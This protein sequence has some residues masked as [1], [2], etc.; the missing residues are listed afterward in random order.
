MPTIL[1][2]LKRHYFLLLLGLILAAL[3][4][5]L[6]GIQWDGGAHM[7]P[8]ER[9]LIMV[10]QRIDIPTN[11]NP[12][13][14]NYGSFPLYLLRLT[15]QLL[16]ATTDT[17]LTTYDG[18][19][20]VGRVLS[21]LADIA[22]L[23]GVMA[24]SL[25]IFKSRA[26]S[27]L[28]GCLWAIA[29][30][31]IQN[32][33]FFVVDVFLTALTTWWVYT[34]LL[35]VHKP[36]LK[37]LWANGILLGLMIATKFTAII[38]IPILFA[39][40][41]I[42][43]RRWPLKHTFLYYFIPMSSA[44]IASFIAMPFMYLEAGKF[45]KDIR[46]QL[47]MNSNAYKFPYTLQYVGTLPYVYF[48]KN[49]A[50]WGLGPIIFILSLVGSW[51]LYH[52]DTRTFHSK[53]FLTCALIYG[54]F[55][56]I[57]GRS[58]VKFMRYLLP[59]Y[60]FFIILAAEGLSFLLKQKNGIKLVGLGLVIT[61]CI[62][63]GMF[64]SIYTTPNT[65]HQAADWILN[66]IPPGSTLAVEH[67]DDRVPGH[68]EDTYTFLELTLYDR[69]D[70]A[71]K[72]AK[73]INTLRQSDYIIVASNRLYAPLTRL[74]DCKKFKKGCY[75]L[76]SAYYKNLFAEKEIVPGLRFKKVAEFTSYPRITLGNTT[77]LTLRDDDAD[78]SF[79]VY[80][81]PK[82]MIFKKQ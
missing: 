6:Q 71:K 43:T 46:E 44:F 21:T 16:S 75:P 17:P 72:W 5:R 50:L 26:K 70:D 34:T 28:A 7:H 54:L 66:N 36:A 74:E 60:P 69:P 11:I 49:I 18:L 4:L 40:I 67:W 1:N 8:D 82:I 48:L 77:L 35:F 61:A 55:F 14:Y 57:I 79:T 58:A 42:F 51:V 32:S 63:T 23:L 9:M 15:A 29:F 39:V 78:E 80:D 73:Q 81:H 2:F 10:A 37:P 12:D 41:F 53:A 59:L 33:H 22:S 45:L 25:F 24:I 56:V 27:F 38:F 30:F 52:K 76:T 19:L 65:R 3:L 20:Y 64:L 13:F 47:A 68:A 31:P 62:W